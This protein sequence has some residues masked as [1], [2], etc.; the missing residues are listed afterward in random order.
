MNET[1]RKAA[2]EA[3]YEEAYAEESFG[4]HFFGMRI[5]VKMSER[6]LVQEDSFYAAADLIKEKLGIVSAKLDPEGPA[7]RESYRAEVQKIY[8]D[9]G[10]TAIFIE[11][12]PNGYCSRPCCLNKPW[13]RVTS[14]IGH[15]VIGWRKS[16]MSIS[17][18]DSL[19]KASG[20]E[21]FPTEDV[22]RLE[23][24]VHAW[25]TE[26]ATKYIRRLHLEDMPK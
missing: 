13:F 16:V 20:M 15:V 11:S 21:L 9:A 4:S 5:F 19:I 2:E 8:S 18:K 26:K 23:T 14:S 24:E 22:T 12:L 10:V 17:W 7:R 6:K 3:G 25:G 1:I